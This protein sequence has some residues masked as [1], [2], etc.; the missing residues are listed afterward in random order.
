[1]REPEPKTSEAKEGKERKGKK[2]HNWKLHQLASAI[3]CLPYRERE[4]ERRSRTS[5]ILITYLPFIDSVASPRLILKL[6]SAFDLNSRHFYLQSSSTDM[7]LLLLHLLTVAFPLSYVCTHQILSV[8]CKPPF[9][10]SC[11][12]KSWSSS[13]STTA[14]CRCRDAMHLSFF[15]SSSFAN[16]LISVLQSAQYSLGK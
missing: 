13:S 15:S 16:I 1:M 7:L 10:Q 8:Q 5:F 2:E 9:A 12:P 6:W 3:Y 4:K 11:S 14:D